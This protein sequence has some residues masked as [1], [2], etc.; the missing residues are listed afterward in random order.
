VRRSPYMCWALLDANV[1]IVRKAVLSMVAMKRLSGHAFPAVASQL[2]NDITQ[3]KQDAEEVFLLSPSF[4]YFSDPRARKISTR[5]ATFTR[6]AHTG[7]TMTPM[8]PTALRRH[9]RPFR[10]RI[11]SRRSWRKRRSVI[12]HIWSRLSFVMKCSVP[13]SMVLLGSLIPVVVL[14]RIIMVSP[15]LSACT[16]HR[17]CRGGR[18]VCHPVYRV[19]LHYIHCQCIARRWK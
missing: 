13:R 12:R 18:P 11:C 4:S 19:E 16:S 2:A 3:Y 7:S 10:R 6:M 15:R 17:H 14:Y 8:F 1:R 9:P 5:S